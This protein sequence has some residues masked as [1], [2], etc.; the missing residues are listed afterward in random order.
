MG[1][2]PKKGRKTDLPQR[3]A[4]D[5]CNA[6]TKAGGYC[7]LK[8]GY[9]TDHVGTGRCKFHGGASHGRPVTSGL[10]SR[11]YNLN[12]AEKT[13][14]IRNNPETFHLSAELL[15]LKA[16]FGELLSILPDNPHDWF[17]DEDLP[18]LR[19]L[20]NVSE[21]IRKTFTAV[22]DAEIKARAYL[23]MA[24]VTSMMRQWG[25]IINDVCKD[26]PFRQVLQDRV[27]ADLRF[28]GGP[29]TVAGA[30]EAQYEDVTGQV[31]DAEKREYDRARKRK[32]RRRRV[33]EKRDAQ[34]AKLMSP[35]KRPLRP[36][37][38][39]S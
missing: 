8:A 38:K 35:A 16:V 19:M 37:T 17:S 39:E 29:A 4:T 18:K 12:L 5:V 6:V 27:L 23:T 20:L 11:S 3:V 36:I 26:C 34:R 7:K 24:D 21:R 2:K 10:Y 9:G 33:E 1:P 13:E 14:E 15:T 32:T 30:V 31:A 25:F 28:P 22:L